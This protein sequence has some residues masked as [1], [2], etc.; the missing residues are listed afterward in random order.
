MNTRL[1]E[2]LNQSSSNE[3]YAVRILE[4]VLT[5]CENGINT[6]KSTA[7]VSQEIRKH[8]KLTSALRHKYKI[9]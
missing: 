1:Q 2:L 8:F 4:E 3:E 5:I 7:D 6:D 9:L